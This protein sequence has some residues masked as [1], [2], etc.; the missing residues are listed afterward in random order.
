LFAGVGASSTL[1]EENALGL[2][3][4]YT[5]EHVAAQMIALLSDCSI[6]REHVVEWVR[7]NGSLATTGRLVAEWITE[8]MRR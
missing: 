3:A 8:D 1:I 2:V 7:E 5:P 6:D 4:E